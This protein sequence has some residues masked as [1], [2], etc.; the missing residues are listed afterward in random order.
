MDLNNS[1]NNQPNA[2]QNSQ[3]SQARFSFE[4]VEDSNKNSPRQN[5]KAELFNLSEHHQLEKIHNRI[6]SQE[7]NESQEN[8]VVIGAKQIF[9]NS[10]VIVNSKQK[11][12]NNY[13]TGIEN[14]A[15]ANSNINSQNANQT[16]Q[17]LL[18]SQHFGQ[19][20]SP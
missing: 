17:Y 9:Q 10:S 4:R 14:A 13:S 8:S 6:D 19:G 18:E 2:K 5:S 11:D 1:I 20:H 3:I 12:P 7:I 16:L 15:N